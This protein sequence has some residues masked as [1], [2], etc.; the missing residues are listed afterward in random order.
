[1]PIIEARQEEKTEDLQVNLELQTEKSQEALRQ[2]QEEAQTIIDDERKAQDEMANKRELEDAGKEGAKL[3]LA[4]LAKSIMGSRPHWQPLESG[5][6][7]NSL[8]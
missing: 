6:G 5:H 8:I 4:N 1:V 7:E 2:L 3:A